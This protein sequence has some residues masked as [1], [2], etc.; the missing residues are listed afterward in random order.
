M[1]H[2]L[3]CQPWQCRLSAHKTGSA[4]TFFLACFLICKT[5]MKLFPHRNL[6]IENMVVKRLEELRQQPRRRVDLQLF[7]FSSDPQAVLAVR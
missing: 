2:S 6:I 3:R 5:G 1:C 4:L 7:G